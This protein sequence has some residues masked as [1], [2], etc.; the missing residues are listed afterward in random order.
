MP[1]AERGFGAI[2]MVNFP[3]RAAAEDTDARLLYALF[4]LYQNVPV[5]GVAV[6]G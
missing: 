2:E 4:I 6:T 1:G 5:K 3:I